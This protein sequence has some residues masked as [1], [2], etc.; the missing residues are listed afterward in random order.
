MLDLQPAPLCCA[1]VC[2]CAFFIYVYNFVCTCVFVCV[3]CDTFTLKREERGK[4]KQSIRLLPW[5]C[6][7]GDTEI[8]SMSQGPCC[9]GNTYE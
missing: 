4:K 7:Q 6:Y 8:L 3:S 5:P 1:D 9:H 2:V